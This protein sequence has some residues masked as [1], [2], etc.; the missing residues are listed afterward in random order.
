MMKTVYKLTGPGWVKVRQA[1]S[2]A[3]ACQLA[4]EL[5]AATGIP[6]CVNS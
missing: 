6:H 5:E 2:F 1:A 4:R 3:H